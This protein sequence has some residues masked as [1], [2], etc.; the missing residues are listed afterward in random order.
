MTEAE[1]NNYPRISINIPVKEYNPH[2]DECIRHCLE[3][4]YPN[5]EIVVLP[6]DACAPPDPAIKIIPTGEVG[7]SD[8]RDIALL[9]SDGEILAYLD[10]DTFPRRDWLRNAVR[11]FHRPQV[12]AVGGPAVTP[13]S[14]GYLQKASGH[15]YSS[16]ACS[17]SLI[18]RYVPRKG[19]EVDDYPTCNFLVRKEIMQTLGGFDNKFWPGEDTIAC[20]RITKELGKKIIYSPEVL[21]YHHRRKLFGPHLK[22][23]WSYAVHRGYFVKKFPETSRRLT[24][25]LPTMFIAGLIGGS[26][27]ALTYP[28][29]RFFFLTALILYFLM[30]F[31]ESLKWKNAAMVPVVILGTFLSHLVY[32]VGFLKGLLAKRLREERVAEE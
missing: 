27:I 29:L 18:Y 6:D 4:D 15:V 12:A 22:Q 23:V 9:H 1:S 3:L 8:K 21:V 30:I 11:H 24:Y 7:P 25:S 10:D 26:L 2:L 31:L 17:G 16:I 13:E 5:F 28:P 19:R 20:L 32:G 14:D